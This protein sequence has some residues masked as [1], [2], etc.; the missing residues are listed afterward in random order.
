MPPDVD[1]DIDLQDVCDR[2]LAVNPFLDNRVNGPAKEG[3][4]VAG[5]HQAAFERLTSLA[6]EALATKRGIGAVLWGEAGIG[7]S[8]LLA[9]L[10]RWAD[11]HATF[12]YLHNL[13]AAPDHLPR[14]L[15]RAVVGALTLGRG[16]RF[17]GTPLTQ[18]VHAGLVEAIDEKFGRHSWDS[19]GRSWNAYVDRLVGGEHPGLAGA[20]RS[21][22]EVLFR[23][24][25]SSYRVSHPY[26]DGT[27][28]EDGSVARWA[29][30]YLSGSALE[31][32][33]ARA[34]NLPPAVPRDEAVA[35]ADAQQIKVV[36]VALA[37]L[38]AA[39]QTPFILAFDQVDNLDTDQASALGRFLE[40]VIDAAPNLLV[41]TAG[42]RATLFRWLQTG[43]IQHSS[44]DRL[45]QFE[46]ELQRVTGVE[47][48][49]MIR[50]RLEDFFRP[51]GDLEGLRQRRH[52]DNYFPLGTAWYE[53]R[54]KDKNDLRPRDAINQACEAWRGEQ[55]RWRNAG[56]AAWLNGVPESTDLPP[57]LV[58]DETPPS[59]ALDRVLD[60]EIAGLCS[61]RSP[62]AGDAVDLAELLRAV[63]VQCRDGSPV[64]G[65]ADVNR[66]PPLRKNQKPH[67]DL[68]I[69]LRGGVDGPSVRVGLLALT[70]PRAREVVVRLRRLTRQLPAVD[71]FVLLT[72]DWIGLPLR[73]R[74]AAYLT[75]LQEHFG[76]RFQHVE[77]TPAEY[78]HLEALRT[79]ALGSR[80][81]DLEAPAGHGRTRFVSEAEVIASH[82]R[83]DR[84]R[85]SRVLRKLFG[86]PAA[87]SPEAP[88][89]L[90][91]TTLSAGVPLGRG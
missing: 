86:T 15:L 37:R 6:G 8:H 55:E 14:S 59:D 62:P 52:A 48:G 91:E 79:T 54:F 88:A 10:A 4:D 89:A 7:K 90:A 13:Q 30:Q 21:I 22:F 84:Y 40:A 9:R 38:A 3:A 73:D 58:A 20:D 18:L 57:P 16:A 71:R 60:E 36:L 24:Y 81:N 61:P 17:Y 85:S 53:G 44:W 32:D 2:A 80:S 70:S 26:A 49:A 41:L 50:A 83:R 72:A 43:V 67:Y 46:V 65:V 75:A 27:R 77:L 11:G 29:V 68:S 34:L 82:H 25:F 1:T 66:V 39:R 33:E 56:V 42:V 76:E 64:Y 51:C 87:A 69:L 45:A 23:L 19:L 5:I 78:L 31:A 63:L 35:L 74:G 12:V 28:R 47:V